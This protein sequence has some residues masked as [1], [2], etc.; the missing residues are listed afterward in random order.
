M[1]LI[2]TFE[3]HERRRR[4]D[5]VNNRAWMELTARA[6]RPAPPRPGLWQRFRQWIGSGATVVPA[7]VPCCAEV[8]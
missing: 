1:L 4:L 5:E 2:A 6:Y 3:A 8:I 7:S